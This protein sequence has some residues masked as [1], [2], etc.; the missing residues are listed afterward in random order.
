MRANFRADQ[1]TEDLGRPVALS[2]RSMNTRRDKGPEFAGG[3]LDPWICL[4][5]FERDVFKP[6]TRKRF[7]DA[8]SCVRS[9][10]RA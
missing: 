3:K 4:S 7:R 2:G 5:K 10:M 8:L 9:G 1:V 6:G